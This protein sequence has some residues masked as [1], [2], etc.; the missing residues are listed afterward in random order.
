MIRHLS[1]AICCLVV[2]AF[3]CTPTLGNESEEQDAWICF[4]EMPEKTDA[5]QRVYVQATLNLD[6][7][8]LKVMS[9]FVDRALT[10]S[11]LLLSY[12]DSDVG[13]L[14]ERFFVAKLTGKEIT[15]AT[16]SL[17]SEELSRLLTKQLTRMG[18]EVEVVAP[19]R[20][21]LR[22]NASEKRTAEF[23]IPFRK[24]STR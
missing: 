17:L 18:Y 1:Q 20:L 5:K 2:F 9:A 21:L 13:V 12:G 16:R 24:A 8:V 6:P 10:Q 19:E 7:K 15:I 4:L 14:T 23:I 3:L 11:T 22:T